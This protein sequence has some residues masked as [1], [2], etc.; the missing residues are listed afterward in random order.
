MVTAGRKSTMD[1]NRKRAHEAVRA[2][3]VMAD[4]ILDIWNRLDALE[5]RTVIQPSNPTHFDA[6]RCQNTSMGQQCD[7][8]AGHDG[9]HWHRDGSNINAWYTDPEQWERMVKVLP[10][11]RELVE[12]NNKVTDSPLSDVLYN[13]YAIDRDYAGLHHDLA[14]IVA[15]CEQQ[16]PGWKAKPYESNDFSTFQLV[17]AFGSVLR[18]PA[19]PALRD[20]QA[21]GEEAASWLKHLTEDDDE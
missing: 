9:V 17:S 15:V 12:K 14:R 3:S 8:E 13:M 20:W 5:Q 1:H 16:V 10:R 11:W 21:L 7:L 19:E 6:L 2:A 4:E 18:N